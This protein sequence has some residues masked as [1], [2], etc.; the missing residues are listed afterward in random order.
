MRNRAIL[1]GLLLVLAACATTDTEMAAVASGESGTGGD[2]RQSL[3]ETDR[4]FSETV[5]DAAAF[6]TF[7]ASD[8]YFLPPDG[9]RVHGPEAFWSG[10]DQVLQ[11]PG[12]RLSWAPNAAEVSAS[13]DLGYT[14]GSFQ[15]KLDGPDGKPVTRAGKYV[16]LWERSQGGSWQVVADTF[17]FDAPM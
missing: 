9:P 12:A 10:I 13:G 1:T 14:I 3:L 7:A 4:A 17:N 6:K 5:D 2:A 16:T 15:L 8:V 11:L